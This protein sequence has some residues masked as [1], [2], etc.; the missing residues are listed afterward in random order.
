MRGKDFRDNRKNG[1]KNLFEYLEK[2]FIVGTESRSRCHKQISERRGYATQEL[3]L[4]DE[5]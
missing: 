4:L 2:R 1:S 3:R 5:K